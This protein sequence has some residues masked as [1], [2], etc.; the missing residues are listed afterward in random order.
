MKDVLALVLAAV[1]LGAA[2]VM[3]ILSIV[4]VVTS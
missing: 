1:L 2:V 4:I 3:N